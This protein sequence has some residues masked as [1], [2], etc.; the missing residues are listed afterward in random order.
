[1]VKKKD[2]LE[3]VSASGKVEA[4][5]EAVLTFQTSGRLA[6]VGVKEGDRVEQWQAIAS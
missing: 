2:L 1:V 5:E 3:S 4:E 6:W